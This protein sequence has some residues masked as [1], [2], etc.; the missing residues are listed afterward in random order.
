LQSRFAKLADAA[1]IYKILGKLEKYNHY[2]DMVLEM[3][4]SKKYCKEYV[5]VALEQADFNFEMGAEQN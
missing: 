2:C 5:A 4:A 1:Y 3:A